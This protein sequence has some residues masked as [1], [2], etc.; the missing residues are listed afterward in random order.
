V[1]RTIHEGPEV[2]NFEDRR[3]SAVLTEGLV[4]TIEPIITA[5]IDKSF[6]T[7]DGWTVVTADRALSAHYEHTVVI[8][9]GDPMVLT[10]VQ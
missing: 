7:S 6:V 2:P 1:G 10:A 3:S 8:T 5:G 9:R 4:I